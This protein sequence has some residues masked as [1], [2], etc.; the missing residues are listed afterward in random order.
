MARYEQTLSLAMQTLAQ[1]KAEHGVLEK[2]YIDSMD[3]DG[4]SKRLAATIDSIARQASVSGQ[5]S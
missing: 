1:I 4:V 3:F 5:A 2:Y